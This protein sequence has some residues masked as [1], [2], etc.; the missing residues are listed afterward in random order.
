MVIAED[1]L[2]VC[3]WSGPSWVKIGADLEDEEDELG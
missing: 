1:G 3:Q 2:G